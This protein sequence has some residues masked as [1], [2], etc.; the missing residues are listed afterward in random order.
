M[1]AVAELG[2][3]SSKA[4][5]SVQYGKPILAFA[6]FLAWADGSLPAVGSTESGGSPGVTIGTL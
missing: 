2:T 5:K 4:K 3:Q 1:L 6:D